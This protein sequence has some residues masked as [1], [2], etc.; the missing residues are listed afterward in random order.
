MTEMT[1]KEKRNEVLKVLRD[2]RKTLV[3]AARRLAL[4]LY[5]STGK[6]V[7]AGQVFD[8][9]WELSKT[10][11]WLIEDLQSFDKRWLGAVFKTSK[12]KCTGYQ[13]EGS[14]ARL[15]ACWKPFLTEDDNQVDSV[16]SVDTNSDS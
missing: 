11:T 5:K 12:W 10:Q 9:L 14:H 1:E 7:T 15:V 16:G 4:D 3:F 13:P 2:K 6:P 8:A